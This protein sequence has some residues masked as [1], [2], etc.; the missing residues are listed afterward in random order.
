MFSDLLL[1][2]P[3]GEMLTHIMTALVVVPVPLVGPVLNE[4]VALLPHLDML[5][6]AL[7]YTMRLEMAQLEPSDS[8]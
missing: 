3:A 4:V 1:Q 7:P 6:R 5:C 8:E 2:S